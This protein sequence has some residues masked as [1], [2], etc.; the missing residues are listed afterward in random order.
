[1]IASTAKEM[2]MKLIT[3]HIKHYPMKD[4]DIIKPY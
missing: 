2:G 1:V 4:V 3:R